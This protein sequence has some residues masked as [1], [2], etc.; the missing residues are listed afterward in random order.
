M[1]NTDVIMQTSFTGYEFDS[2]WLRIGKDGLLTVKGSNDRGYAW[3]GCSP[4]INLLQI[5]W[6]TADGMLDFRTAKPLTYYASM[7]HDALYQYK[8][9]VP[10]SRREADLLFTKILRDAGFIWW[11]LYG[12]AVIVGGSLYGGWKTKQSRTGTLKIVSCS[13]PTTNNEAMEEISRTQLAA[14]QKNQAAN[15][16][17]QKDA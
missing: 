5:T 4:K 6:G 16:A 10:V 12:F 11:W 3:D 14:L 15:T 17:K 1:H 9:D 7:I 8:K 13:W 2:D